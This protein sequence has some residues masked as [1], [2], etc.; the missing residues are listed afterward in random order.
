MMYKSTIKYKYIGCRKHQSRTNA[1]R[2]GPLPPETVLLFH[3]VF[4]EFYYVFYCFGYLLIH[5]EVEYI[6]IFSIYCNIFIDYTALK[7]VALCICACLTDRA[8]F[9]RSPPFEVFS[10]L[11]HPSSNFEQSLCLGYRDILVL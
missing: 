10:K 4:S 9:G 1:V 8:W 11:F 7:A 5:F 3:V 2:N 6:E